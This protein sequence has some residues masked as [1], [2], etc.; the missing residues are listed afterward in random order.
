MFITY[1]QQPNAPGL[2]RVVLLPDDQMA[3]NGQVVGSPTVLEL[4]FPTTRGSLSVADGG[5]E[6]FG[7]MFSAQVNLTLPRALADIQD[8]LTAHQD[9]RYILYIEDA[10]GSI[11]RIGG[12]GD[13]ATHSL[14]YNID[15]GINAT[16]ISFT[17]SSPVALPYGA[18]GLVGI[19]TGPGIIDGYSIEDILASSSATV[20]EQLSMINV[21]ATWAAQNQAVSTIPEGYELSHSLGS[22]KVSVQ[23]FDTD[24]TLRTDI[25][26]EVLDANTI[27]IYLPTPDNGLTP[28]FTGEVFI[29]KRNQ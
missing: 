3:A 18:G 1:V 5:D 12:G 21:S 16:N 8:F 6:P 19:H 9:R 11:H 15:A 14:S 17:H 26:Y 29:I 24:G 2:R 4:H 20:I 28:V 7:R 13:G 23:F 10:N 22:T 27:K 25:A